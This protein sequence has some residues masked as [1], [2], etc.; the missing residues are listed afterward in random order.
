MADVEYRR[1]EFRGGPYDGASDV[2]IPSQNK[3]GFYVC[4]HMTAVA[5]HHYISDHPAVEY[6][7]DEPIIVGHDPQDIQLRNAATK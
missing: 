2:F 5:I 6:W 4:L 3:D 7:S 1:M